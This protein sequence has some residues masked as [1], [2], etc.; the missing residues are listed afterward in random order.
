VVAGLVGGGL[1]GLLT[2]P[3]IEPLCR[4]MADTYANYPSLER[5]RLAFYFSMPWWLSVLA[6]VVGTAAPVGM[7]ALAVWLARPRDVWGDLSAGITAALAGT[8]AALVSG[9]GWLVVLA[10]VVVPSISDLTLLGDAVRPAGAAH[11]SEVLAK[12]Y[13][14]LRA[15]EPDRRGAKVM[16]KIVT[17]QVA[18]SAAATWIAAVLALLTAGTLALGGTLAA[19]YLRRRGGALRR[20]V[21]PYFELTLPSTVTAG[22]L[23]GSV[24]SAVWKELLGPSPF[25]NHGPTLLGLSVFAALIFAGVVRRWSILLRVCLALA[26]A[27]LL[28]NSRD[29]IIVPWFVPAAAAVV[30]GLHYARRTSAIPRPAAGAAV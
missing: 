3:V 12:R 23:V 7:G 9:F 8:L 11:P 24:F 18:G 20:A 22:L 28:M 17:D 21:L 2:L 10:M 25:P 19:G 16:P 15:I 4:N 13:P 29:P 30:L 6:V 1:T 26:W 14:D 27:G 5:P